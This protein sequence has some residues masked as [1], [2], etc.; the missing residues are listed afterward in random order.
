M[1]PPQ[2][3]Q[4]APIPVVDPNAPLAVDAA[5]QDLGISD[6]EKKNKV[7]YMVGIVFGVI[8]LLLTTILLYFY[9]NQG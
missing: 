9:W 7:L 1:Y 6:T 4:G 5:P 3:Q 2:P 8:T